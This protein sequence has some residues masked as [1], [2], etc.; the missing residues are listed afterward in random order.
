MFYLLIPG[1]GGQ[2]VNK[3]NTK[4]DLR[5]HVATA[6]WLSE[7]TRQKLQQEYKTRITKEGFLIIKSDVTRYQQMNVADAL[8]K[9]RTLI[10]EIERPEP[11]LSEETL[12]RIRRKQEKMARE[13]LLV[14][15]QHSQ[16]KRDRQAP[17][18]DL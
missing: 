12:E 6:E 16:T 18:V 5:F 8:E 14:K 13:R 2:N 10:R 4:V 1:A 3:V 17:T 15:R 11:T 7:E 9:L